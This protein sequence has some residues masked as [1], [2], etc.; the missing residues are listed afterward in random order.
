MRPGGRQRRAD[1]LDHARLRA[2]RYGFNGLGSV[3]PDD[4]LPLVRY[5]F[6]GGFTDDGPV[7]L[8]DGEL[9]GDVVE[10]ADVEP[11]LKEAFGKY[12]DRL[13][14]L[15]FITDQKENVWPMVKAGKGLT[16]MLLGS[17]DL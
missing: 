7:V 16:E 10:T 1:G 6:I 8:L 5:G 14:F 11:V 4:G 13:V 3:G 15:D 2:D 12:K 9:G 17:E